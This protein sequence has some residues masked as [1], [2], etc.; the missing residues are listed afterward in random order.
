MIHPSAYIEFPT[1]NRI[2]LVT[3]PEIRFD[4][5]GLLNQLEIMAAPL[6]QFILDP[7]ALISTVP[8]PQILTSDGQTLTSDGVELQW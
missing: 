2:D 3:P 8:P 4:A 5:A 7:F 1:G 6:L